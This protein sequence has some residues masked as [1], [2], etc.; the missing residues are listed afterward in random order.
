VLDDLLR[1]HLY[2]FVR[3]AFAP[4]E[5]DWPLAFKHELLAFPNGRNDDQVD[6]MAQALDWIGTRRGRAK[7]ELRMNGGRPLA[8]ARPQGYRRPP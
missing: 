8:P 1:E 2:S 3:M 5:A 4:R 6:S 7:C